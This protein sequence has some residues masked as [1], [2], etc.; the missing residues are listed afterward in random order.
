M[1]LNIIIYLCMCTVLIQIA[2]NDLS[3]FNDLFNNLYQMVISMSISMPILIM[4]AL[5]SMILIIVIGLIIHK[6]K[7]DHIPGPMISSFIPIYLSY[8]IFFGRIINVSKNLFKRFGPVVKTSYNTIA[9]MDINAVHELLT[10]KNILKTKNNSQLPIVKYGL[11]FVSDPIKAETYRKY[12]LQGALNSDVLRH[13]KGINFVEQCINPMIERIHE[14]I[15]KNNNEIDIQHESFLLTKDVIASALFHINPNDSSVQ[16]DKIFQSGANAFGRLKEI[17][18]PQ[19]VLKIIGSKSNPELDKFLNHIMNTSQCPLMDIYAKSELNE[20]EKLIQLNTLWMAGTDTSAFALHTTMILLAKHQCIQDEL[21]ELVKQ[22]FDNI[23]E[24]TFETV[25][26]RIPYIKSVIYESLRYMAPIPMFKTRVNPIENM[27]ICG[28]NIPANTT[29]NIPID[30]CMNPNEKI[31]D[32]K[33]YLNEKHM[34]L[35]FGKGPRSC[36]GSRLAEIELMTTVPLL[37]YYFKW[38]DPTPEISLED[39]SKSFINRYYSIN[40]KLICQ[41]L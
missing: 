39:I 40:Y 26:E 5:I 36:P 13:M 12:M 28:Y 10:N 33:R 38:I 31:F 27:N 21:R 29:I 41:E 11:P 35:P 22:N 6:K 20:Q 14:S 17:I 1:I 3:S 23:N 7:L 16:I 32:P 19:V 37:V 30:T 2:N 15:N 24:L 4:T 18:L 34:Y 9:I 25:N 8:E